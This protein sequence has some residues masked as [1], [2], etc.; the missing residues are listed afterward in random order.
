MFGQIGEG[1]FVITSQ[2]MHD[3]LNIISKANYLSNTVANYHQQSHLIFAQSF[4]KF[5]GKVCQE[6]YEKA[7]DSSTVCHLM[8]AA[9]FNEGGT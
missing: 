5:P 1:E 3:I 8:R 7:K 4:D 2:Q 6:D 9:L